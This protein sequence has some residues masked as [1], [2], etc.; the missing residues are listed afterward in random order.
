MTR[1]TVRD[2]NTYFSIPWYVTA[3]TVV[4]G[5]CSVRTNNVVDLSSF[6]FLRSVV[7]GDNCF[8]YVPMLT[9]VGLNWLESVNI[10]YYTFVYYGMQSL[11]EGSSFKI[12][13]CPR[14]KSLYIRGNSCYRYNWFELA[15]LPQLKS[16]VMGFYDYGCFVRTRNAVFRG[17]RERTDEL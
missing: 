5:A 8:N 13:N 2:W 7:I 9:I 4:N 12:V 11:L 3:L 14:L 15:Q 6:K 16:I 10:G 1:Y 17:K